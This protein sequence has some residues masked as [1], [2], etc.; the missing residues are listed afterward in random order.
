MEYCSG[1]DLFDKVSNMKRF[2]EKQ[3]AM[4]M[5]QIFSA[6]AYLHARNFVH[7]DLKPENILIDDSQHDEEGIFVK[8]IDF[9][10]ASYLNIKDQL[11]GSYGTIYYM[12]PE[13]FRVADGYDSK[14]DIWSLGVVFYE[15][16]AGEPPF[17]ARR[18]EEIPQAQ[19]NLKPLP[20]HLT[21]TP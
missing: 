2:T 1:G 11:R 12:A 19:L 9:D 3:A 21:A 15:I 18:R 7:R 13:I 5:K 6:V 16:L 20:A 17:T 10:T 8:V 4:V 14:A